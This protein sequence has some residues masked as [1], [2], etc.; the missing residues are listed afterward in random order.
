M[1]NAAVGAKVLQQS[2]PHHHQLLDLVIEHL[3]FTLRLCKSTPVLAQCL[4]FVDTLLQWRLEALKNNVEA[5]KGGRVI[6][7]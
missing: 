2:D 3:L 4:K 1:L 6:G 7:F 5:L